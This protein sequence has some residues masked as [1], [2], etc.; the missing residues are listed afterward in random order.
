[1]VSIRRSELASTGAAGAVAHGALQ[2][3]W[4]ARGR[5][6]VETLVHWAIATQMVERFASVG[7]HALEAEASGFLVK[8]R[9][10]CGV[11][12]MIEIGDLGC[13]IDVSGPVRDAVH[14]VAY[15]VD[16][17]L[18]G[19][20][21]EQALLVRTHARSGS[22]PTQWQPPERFIRPAHYAADG[23]SA[24][25]EYEGP[26]RKGAFCSIIIVWDAARQQF[27]RD[28]YRRW[29][30]GLDALAWE[31]SKLNLGFTVDGPPAPREP[32]A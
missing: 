6:D 25:V 3:P 9:S 26:G 2:R 23:V 31:C 32:W 5:I 4:E 17:A 15:A 10:T 18:A 16:R 13:E 7:L 1:M 28:T 21:W 24:A 8:A 30:D 29:W 27:G 22:R 14:P 19:V 12:R 11:A 20:E